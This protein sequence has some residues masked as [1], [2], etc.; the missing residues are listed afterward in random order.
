L[1]GRSIPTSPRNRQVEK[2]RFFLPRAE[3]VGVDVTPEGN[4]PAESKYNALKGLEQPI[5]Y[6]NLSMLIGIVGFYRN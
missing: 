4:F 2:I 3:F 6:S 5:L 1:Y